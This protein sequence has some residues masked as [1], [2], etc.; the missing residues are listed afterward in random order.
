V[1][2]NITRIEQARAS[3]RRQYDKIGRIIESQDPDGATT[4]Y[5]YG[6]HSWFLW[7]ELDV[8]SPHGDQLQSRVKMQRDPLGCI[9]EEVPTLGQ[10]KD[11][12]RHYP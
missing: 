3:S 5:Q 2:G 9:I 10:A 12:A 1:Q 8:L 7:D 4:R 6:E 11:F